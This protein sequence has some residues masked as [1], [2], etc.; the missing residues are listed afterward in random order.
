MAGFP[1]PRESGY[2]LFRVGHAGT[3]ISTAIGMARGDSQNDEGHRRV[4]VL[5]GDSSIV[6]GVADPKVKS[7]GLTLLAYSA[8][9]GGAY[10][11][12]D[13]LVPEAYLGPD[14]EAR[15]AALKRVTEET[16]ATPNQV[17]LAWM[18]QSQPSILPLIAA[19]TSAQLQ[20]NIEALRLQLS[21]K[22]LEQLTTAGI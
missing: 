12:P 15:L 21:A 1:E 17:I 18:R 20:E 8:L 2:D 14:S 9:L 13:R 19:S 10:T 6:N 7:E 11:R 4:V 22:Q 3:G 5:V 16:G